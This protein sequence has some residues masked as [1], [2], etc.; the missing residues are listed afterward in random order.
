MELTNYLNKYKIIGV[1]ANYQCSISGDKLVRNILSTSK[2]EKLLIKFNLSTELLDKN[3]SQL[4]V[5]E[6][7]KIDL[8]SKLN[9][10]II[11]IGNLSS[12]LI[13][14]DRMIILKL[15]KKL[16]ENYNKKIIIIDDDMNSL[17]NICNYFLVLK[18]KKIVYK[19]ENVYDNKLYNYCRKPEIVDFVFRAKEKNIKLEDYTDLYELIKAIYR[20][21]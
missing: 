13:Y 1:I 8:L 21:L 9:Q 11:V 2:K 16:N 19:T 20:S 7:L 6:K 12:S 3:F 18:N 5:S 17:M 15:L 14:R 4:S 10:D